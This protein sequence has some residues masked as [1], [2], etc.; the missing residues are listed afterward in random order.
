[1]PKP[2]RALFAACVGLF[3]GL[4]ASSTDATTVSERSLRDLAVESPSIVH[5]KVVSTS[6]RWTEDQALIVTDVV[7][8]VSDTLKGSSTGRIVVT[9]PGGRVGKLR[10]DVAGANAFRPGEETVLFLQPSGDGTAIV[11]GLF[12][13]RFGVVPDARGRRMVQGLSGDQLGTLQRASARTGRPLSTVP[14]NPV[15]LDEFLGGMR[16]L[17]QDIQTEGGR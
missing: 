9:Q 1:M 15:E 7:I 10:V 4:S 5:G 6:S 12:Q 8:E 2:S 17:L 13:G 3:W 11:T 16:S 14:G